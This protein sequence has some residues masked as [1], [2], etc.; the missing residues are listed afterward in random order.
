MTDP[1]GVYAAATLKL[2][3]LLPLA[4]FKIMAA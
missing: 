2:S 4:A 3:T 1:L